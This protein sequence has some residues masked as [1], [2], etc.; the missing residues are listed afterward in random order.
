[1]CNFIC[2]LSCILTS[3]NKQPLELPSPLHGRRQRHVVADGRTARRA[4]SIRGCVSAPVVCAARFHTQ[5]TLREVP[6]EYS[7]RGLES[8]PFPCDRKQNALR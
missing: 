1:M 2:A 7:C 4:A 8:N 3:G 6:A 5:K